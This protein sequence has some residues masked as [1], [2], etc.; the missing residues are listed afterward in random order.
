MADLITIRTQK[1]LLRPWLE[2]DAPLLARYADN[3]R[4]SAGLRDR[5]PSPYTT[6]DARRFISMATSP[7]RNILLAIEIQDEAAGSIGIH[8]LGDVYCRTAEIGY[9]LAEPF[10]GK[11]IVTDAVRALVPVAFGRTDLI[12]IQAGVFA[13][14]PASMRVLEKSGF[15]REAVHRHAITKRGI[16]LDEVMY[17]Q[18]RNDKGDG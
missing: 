13:D 17:V 3:P 2:D 14:N 10:W 5:F 6:D 4:I 15:A 18:F 1:A 8:P 11:G 16:T 9:W 12:R 7:S